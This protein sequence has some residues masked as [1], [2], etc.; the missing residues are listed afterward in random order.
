MAIYGSLREVFLGF[1][2]V[3]RPRFLGG[4]VGMKSVKTLFIWADGRVG[5][6]LTTCALTILFKKIGRAHV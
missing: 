1:P 5:W 6:A 3:K 2:G 4:G